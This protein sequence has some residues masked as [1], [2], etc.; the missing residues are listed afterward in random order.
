MKRLSQAGV[1]AV[2]RANTAGFSG[3]SLR[4]ALLS[5]SSS[6]GPK[7]PATTVP[8]DMPEEMLR[9]PEKKLVPAHT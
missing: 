8:A 9:T 6:S 2:P 4:K 3:A 7:S 1:E 5:P